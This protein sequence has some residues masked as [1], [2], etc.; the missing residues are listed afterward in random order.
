[1][2]G[3]L[4]S[5]ARIRILCLALV[6]PVLAF[7]STAPTVLRAQQVPSQVEPRVPDISS[8][9]FAT[10]EGT[11]QIPSLR[12]PE[13][14]APPGAEDISV[15]LTKVML[16]GVTAYDEATLAALY[17]DKIG[18][19]LSLVELFDIA[20]ALEARYR[21]DGFILSRVVVP[22]QTIEDGVFRIEV[23]EGYID[24]VTYVGEI[25]D[26]RSVVEG[27]LN[28]LPS[29][30]P[31]NIDDLERYL[32]L[33]NDV[34]GV[35][36]RGVL[37][38]STEA[39]GAAQLVIN[40][41]RQPIDGFG[42]VDNR[43]SEFTGPYQAIGSVGLNSFTGLGERSELTFLTALDFPE[44]RYVGGSFEGR[45]GGEGLVARAFASYSEGEPGFT[46]DPLNVH[47]DALLVGADLSFPLLRGRQTSLWIK[48]GGEHYRS[49]LEVLNQDF[50]EDRLWV[51]W[52]GLSAD[53]RDQLQGAN[54]ADVKL[55]HGFDIFDASDSGDPL[56]SRRG[57]DGSFTS[58]RLDLARLQRLS[59]SVRLYLGAAFQYAFDPVLASE[60]FALGGLAFGRGYDPA[61]L[62]DDNGLA[63]TLELQIAPG[64]GLEYVENYHVYGFYDIGQVWDHG[65]SYGS[66][67]S[68]ASLG[69]GARVAVTEWLQIDGEVAVPLTKSLSAARGNDEAAQFFFTVTTR[70]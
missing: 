57:A 44:N 34:P 60:E 12:L 9:T 68:L 65:S 14:G 18:Q 28:K 50:T 56:N 1:M 51:A 23:I 38:P 42:R 10:P 22:A 16:D 21:S 46:L 69:F 49:D 3:I 61:E 31:V 64:L 27:Y 33:S 2:G 37:Q 25:G 26:A 11:I 32:L 24:A 54:R 13:T 5:E 6:L 41:E 62:T 29:F 66:G 17:D 70:F 67:Q 53:H 55:R 35:V 40:M 52:L 20:Q 39:R 36:V 15:V 8:G 63:G 7:V 43:A 58:L 47:S 59:D 19:E 45:L 4:G 48:G 30:R